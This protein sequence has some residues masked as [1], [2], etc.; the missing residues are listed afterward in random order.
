MTK[1]SGA[2]DRNP[3]W[4]PDGK[5]IAYWSDRSGENEI[6]LQP[7]DDNSKAKRI[8]KREKGF[9]YNL[10]W[11]PNSK[12]LAF[13]DEKND[14]SVLD[15]ESEKVAIAGNT[16]WNLGHGA[17]FGYH[18]SWSP[19]SRWITFI[20]GAEN[21]NNAIFFYDVEDRKSYQITSGFYNDNYPVFSTD[22]DKL[23]LVRSSTAGRLQV[24]ELAEMLFSIND[25]LERIQEQLG[26]ITGMEL[27]PGEGEL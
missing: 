12:M 15:V 22:G 1:S 13:I 4:S 5:F 11:S 19:D 10:F 14:I 2:F 9:G 21:S 6:Y 16:R 7:S 8:T 27:K 23:R 17:R 18:I 3:A 25:V 24:D 26:L 20:E